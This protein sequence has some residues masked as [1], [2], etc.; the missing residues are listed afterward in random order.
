[1]R[2]IL[3]TWRYFHIITW[4]HNSWLQPPP[5]ARPSPQCFLSGR[6]TDFH[7]VLF[8]CNLGI[9]FLITRNSFHAIEPLPHKLYVN[10]PGNLLDIF[11]EALNSTIYH[12]ELLFYF[13]NM[14]F[15]YLFLQ[16]SLPH[17]EHP[18]SGIILGMVSAI[19]TIVWFL[20]VP[21]WYIGPTAMPRDG[22]HSQ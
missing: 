5:L 14:H 10:N 15:Q 2:L 3:E 4:P 22:C 17:S 1:M 6:V 16:T 9:P 20:R 13:L 11:P 18:S 7:V 12:C 8:T 19:Y 21:R